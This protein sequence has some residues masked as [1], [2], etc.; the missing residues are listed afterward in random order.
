MQRW[1]NVIN[2][3]EDTVVIVQIC[4][5]MWIRNPVMSILTLF[6]LNL[7][8]LVGESWFITFGSPTPQNVVI[9][10]TNFFTTWEKSIVSKVTNICDNGI[11]DLW[12]WK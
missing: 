8:V 9:G 11:F 7:L 1:Q 2:V 3:I 5:F 4:I 12:I 6:K 10:I